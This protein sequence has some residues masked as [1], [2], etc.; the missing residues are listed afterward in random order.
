[1]EYEDSIK[2]DHLEAKLKIG[3]YYCAYQNRALLFMA[4]VV[5]FTD[6][7]IVFREVSVFEGRIICVDRKVFFSL[8]YCPRF[9][10][11]GIKNKLLSFFS[12][13]RGDPFPVYSLT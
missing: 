6:N 3:A 12:V 1:M 13:F 7:I 2:L 5:R 11:Y 4:Y 8:E 9:V 10:G